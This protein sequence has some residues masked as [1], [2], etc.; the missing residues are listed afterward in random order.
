MAGWN[1]L[2]SGYSAPQTWQLTPTAAALFQQQAGPRLGDTADY[3]LRGAWA[4]QGGGD[5]GGAHLTDL[6]KLPNHPTFSTQS[7]YQTPTQQGGVWTQM[8]GGQWVFVPSETNIRNLGARGL[9]EYF[10][11]VE[12]NSLLVMP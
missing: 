9:Q 8:P 6:W 3:D 5:L 10:S 7:R 11:R 12:P 1:A 4:Q 2:M